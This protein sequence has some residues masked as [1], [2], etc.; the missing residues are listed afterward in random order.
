MNP[1]YTVLIIFLISGVV[2]SLMRQRVTKSDQNMENIVKDQNAEAK[3]AALCET[4]ETISVVCRGYKEE[5]YVLTDRRLIIDNKKGFHSIP[6]D[7]I[8]GIDF[9]K[10]DGG[11]PKQASECQVMT[12][13]ADKKYPMARYSGKFDQISAHFFNW[14]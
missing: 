5:Y 2:G 11:K 3:Y 13:H 12:V 10:S 1:L 6:L 7:T 4:G 9:R 14:P 8:R